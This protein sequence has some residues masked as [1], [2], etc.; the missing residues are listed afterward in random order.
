[1]GAREELNRA[2]EKIGAMGRE[3]GTYFYYLF[4]I[5]IYLSYHWK[6][7]LFSFILQKEGRGEECGWW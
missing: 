3:K 4:L 6:L 2:R 5:F 7:L 1:M